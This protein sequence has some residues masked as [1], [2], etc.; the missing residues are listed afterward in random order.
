MLGAA[1]GGAAATAILWATLNVWTVGAI[2]K[3]VR[4]LGCPVSSYWLVSVVGAVIAMTA[5]LRDV[6]VQSLDLA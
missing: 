6:A 3:I 1:I 2:S 5:C 4:E